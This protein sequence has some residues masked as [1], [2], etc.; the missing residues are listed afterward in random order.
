MTFENELPEFLVATEMVF[1]AQ[2]IR[3]ATKTHII[4]KEVMTKHKIDNDN[5]EIFFVRAFHI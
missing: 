4:P 1:L 2:L 3:N 5:Y